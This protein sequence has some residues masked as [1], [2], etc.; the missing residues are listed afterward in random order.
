[1]EVEVNE[2]TIFTPKELSMKELTYLASPIESKL[3]DFLLLNI[4][5]TAIT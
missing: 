3:A 5:K 1:M 2:V 4:R